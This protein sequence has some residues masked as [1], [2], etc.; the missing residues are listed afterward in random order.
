MTTKD[1]SQLYYLD[2]EIKKQE[3]QLEKLEAEA[4][5]AVAKVSGM[6]RASDV[7]DKVGNM[8]VEI[9]EART[10]IHLNLQKRWYERN[11][12]L[13]YINTVEDSLMRQILTHRFI[14][15]MKW[16]EVADAVGGNHTSGSVRLMCHRFL[17]Q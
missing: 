4:F 7:S 9:A 5:N 1:L 13:R 11:R 6:P 3:E 10:L 2:Q 14:D 16:W 17:K 15:G 12:L 8:A